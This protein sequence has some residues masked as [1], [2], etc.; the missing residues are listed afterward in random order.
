V[1]QLNA[2]GRVLVAAPSSGMPAGAVGMKVYLS[3]TTNAET[4]QGT[5]TGTAAFIQQ[6]PLVA[7]AAVP[8]ANATLCKQIAN[9][10]I[11]PSGTGYTVAM[12]DPS[13]NTI[14][15]YPMQ[16]QLMGP[17][18]TINLSSGL[19]YYHGTVFFPTPILASP[20]N[21]ALQ[22]IAGPLSLTGYSLTNVGAIGVG[23]TLPAYP[24][25][26]ENGF[27]N[28]NLGYL[29]NG[30]AG[31]AG[32]VLAS[33]GPGG[34]DTWI[35]PANA[36]VFYQ[37]VAVNGAAQTQR[38]VLNF[39]PYFTLSDSASP[40]QTTVTAHVTGPAD[41]YLVTSAGS[42]VSGHCA[43]WD[44]NGGIGDGGACTSTTSYSDFIGSRAI[45]TV[46]QNPNASKMSLFVTGFTS[47]GYGADWGIDCMVGA[48][49]GGL[50]FFSH[51]GVTNSG[52]QA[53]VVCEVPPG[54]FY[55]VVVDNTYLTNPQTATL[56]H[57]IEVLN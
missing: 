10:T 36:T 32:Q 54:F 38:P 29:V 12:M 46:Y 34:P 11:W 55:E 8:T 50:S 39:S 26:V 19:P 31:T 56:S 42:G 21:H 22:S 33:G 1:V 16:W 30:S 25:D 18:T 2:T 24:I 27:I 57:W 28:S 7:G 5:T 3:T 14:P 51:A 4:L 17:N 49:S 35:T 45:T 53:T 23:T 20:L 47:T 6:T 44:G 9:D 41:A 40:A 37:T 52:G 15:G 48:T 13:G 43:K